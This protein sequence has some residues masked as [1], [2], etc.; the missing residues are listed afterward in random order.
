MLRIIGGRFKGRT[1]PSPPGR[2]V[3]PTMAR[4]RESLFQRLEAQINSCR[5][6]DLFAGS[7]IMGLEAL[8]RNAA[9]LLAVDS[10]R[11]QIKHLHEAF[12]TLDIGPDEAKAIVMDACALIKRQNREAPFDVIFVDPP[13]GKVKLDKVIQDLDTNGWLTPEGLLIV[14]HER[15]ES[16]PEGFTSYEFGDT[17]IAIREP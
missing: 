4:I 15:R 14:E 8:S 11:Q 12:E 1:L 17:I 10:N 5:F 2:T 3:R 13:Y 9:F 16:I 6:L 7:G